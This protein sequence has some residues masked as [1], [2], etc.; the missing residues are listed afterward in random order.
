MKEADT[1]DPPQ[2]ERADPPT[3]AETCMR[4]LVGRASF[5]HIR[6]VL[7]P[8]LRYVVMRRDVTCAD[9]AK[10]VFLVKMLAIT[11]T[12]VTCVCCVNRNFSTK[13]ERSASSTACSC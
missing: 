8:V 6:S 12:V 3:L 5:G 4:E 13:R 9:S 2:E 7:R 1:P 10:E 11:D